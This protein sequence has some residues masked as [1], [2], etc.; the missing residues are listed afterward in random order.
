MF[1]VLTLATALAAAVAPAH[2]D[3]PLSMHGLSANGLTSNALTQNGI[4]P[5]TAFSGSV[6]GIELPS[7]TDQAR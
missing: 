2:A 6:V 4:E 5:D 1:K 7:A 3:F